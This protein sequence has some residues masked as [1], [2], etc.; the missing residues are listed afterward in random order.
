M[1]KW[2][3]RT[4]STLWRQKFRKVLYN[5][6]EKKRVGGTQTRSQM[7]RARL[8]CCCG[9]EYCEKGR[10]SHMV[11]ATTCRNRFR[12]KGKKTLDLRQ[13]VNAR[14]N[15][16]YT[17]PTERFNG[18]EGVCCMYGV[19]RAGVRRRG[20]PKYDEQYE[21]TCSSAASGCCTCTGCAV[22]NIACLSVCIEIKDLSV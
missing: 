14:H 9:T 7:C 5:N 8:L 4:G 15:T 20:I 13:D 17:T 6:N 12:G 19:A 18:K 22:N 1:Y 3:T 21:M 10:S 11:T 16:I 2:N